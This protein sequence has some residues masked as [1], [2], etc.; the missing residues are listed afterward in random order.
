VQWFDGLDAALSACRALTPA[1]EIAIKFL[2]NRDETSG[3]CPACLHPVT[4]QV[5]SDPIGASWRNFLEGMIC[6]CGTNARTRLIAT[7]W[8]EVRKSLRPKQSLIFERVTTTY[9]RMA[10]EDSR[11]VGCEYL[12]ADKV[13]GQSYEHGTLIIRHEDLLNLSVED[14]SLDLIMHFDVLEHVPDH[15]RA[16]AEC[17]RV[18][19]AG[20]KMLF[21]LPF[22]HNLERHLI[23]AQ[24]TDGEIEHLLPPAFHGNPVG[25][26][27]LVFIHPGRELISELAEV[28]FEIRVGLAHNL[29]FG[30][31]SNGC[32]WPDGHTWPLI[33]LATK[34]VELPATH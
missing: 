11:L 20:G 8:R 9:D 33:F 32:P 6:P 4:F 34:T 30:I 12:G 29:G 31:V 7:A 16:L 26:G 27:A 10:A 17:H 25:D 24:M 5:S 13:P 23:R 21:T 14:S 22:Y 19:R 15:R 2:E 28:G 3:F 18:L 1:D